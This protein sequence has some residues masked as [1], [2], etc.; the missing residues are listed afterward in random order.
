MAGVALELISADPSD[1]AKVHTIPN[2][3]CPWGTGAH[4]TMITQ[5]LLPTS[6][7]EGIR[8]PGYIA[9]QGSIAVQLGINI[10]Y[11]NCTE[12]FDTIC[13]VYPYETFWNGFSGLF[14]GQ[15]HCFILWIIMWCRESS[16]RQRTLIAGWWLGRDPN[17]RACS[18]RSLSEP[19]KL[20]LYLLGM[21][22]WSFDGCDSRV[23]S[24]TNYNFAI[25]VLLSQWGLLPLM[26]S[27]RDSVVV[28]VL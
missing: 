22:G 17:F 2:M 9:Y 10:R 28:T 20:R 4:Y 15:V 3:R 23:L 5:N 12:R 24:W 26:F 8:G 16:C 14:L 18:R 1:D 7:L 13:V 19:L 21:V 25:T 27:S 6:F 11:T